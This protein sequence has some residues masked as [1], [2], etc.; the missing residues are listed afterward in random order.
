MTEK[1]PWLVF[2]LP[3]VVYMLVGSLEPS[4]TE[5]GG[6]LLGL[7]LQYSA[8]PVIYTVKIAST[9]LCMACVFPGYRQFHR[10]PS[11]LAVGVGILGIVVW[12]GLWKISAQSGLTQWLAHFI[13][14]GGRPEYNP[15]KELAA[16]PAWAWGFLAIRFLG[17]VVIVPIIEEFFLRG[18]LMRLVMEQDWWKVPFGRASAGAIAVSIVVPVLT[19]PT[20][21]LAAAVWFG[22][23]TWLMIRTRN[24]WDCVVAHAV[25]NLLLGIYV[26]TTGNWSLW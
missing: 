25:T 22:M 10:R 19:H 15:L 21:A 17:L 16:S 9:L 20:E 18:F 13:G 11:L 26:V 12:I 23:V 2:V 7:N 4:P 6:K 3:F 8:Y 1:Y 14:L 5:P 24:I